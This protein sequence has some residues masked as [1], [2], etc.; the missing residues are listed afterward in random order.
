ML[1]ERISEGIADEQRLNKMLVTGAAVASVAAADTVNAAAATATAIAAALP[2]A[3]PAGGTGAAAGGW[4]T[5]ANR[6][7]AIVTINDMRTW[8][9][10]MDLDYEAILVDV[11][12]IRTKYAAAVTLGNENKAQINALLA[13]LRN[14]KIIGV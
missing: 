8:A 5:A 3:A 14:R 4:D 1:V 10:E 9:V 13:E 7:A 2:A 6:D 12:D 11:A